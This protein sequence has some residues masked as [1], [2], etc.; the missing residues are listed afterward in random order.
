VIEIPVNELIYLMTKF[1][2]DQLDIYDGPN[3]KNLRYEPNSRCLS[4]V[5]MPDNMKIEEI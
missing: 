3:T 4:V 2:Y 5:F 1:N